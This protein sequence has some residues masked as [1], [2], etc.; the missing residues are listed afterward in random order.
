MHY[1]ANDHTLSQGL[2]WIVDCGHG[3]GTWSRSKRLWIVWCML[4]SKLCSRRHWMSQKLK[5]SLDQGGSNHS[6]KH[7]W[8]LNWP[9]CSSYLSRNQ[10][11]EIQRHGEAGSVNIQTVE[12]EWTCIMEI[13]AR[14]QPEDCWN[15]DES[16]LFAFVPPDHG[17][18]QRQMSGKWANKFELQYFT[19][20]WEWP[21]N[22]KL[23]I[24]SK[25][26]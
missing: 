21:V 8:T 7:E 2:M 20:R 22:E 12:E 25:L 13:L 10:L 19:T 3:F 24:G 9:N 15:V 26:G 23:R 1:Q 17:L 6:V 5:G 18:S 11:K 16:V 14:F 4:Q